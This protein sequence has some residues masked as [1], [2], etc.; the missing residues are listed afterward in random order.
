M[1]SDRLSARAPNWLLILY[2]GYGYG[3]ILGSSP[4][5]PIYLAGSFGLVR[6]HYYCT[7]VQHMNEIQLELIMT[8]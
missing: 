1:A 7:R 3:Y 5:P 8:Y 4:V 6:P 2:Y